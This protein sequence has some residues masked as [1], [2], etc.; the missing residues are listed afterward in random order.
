MW[1]QVPVESSWKVKSSI[2][3]GGR[4]GSGKGKKPKKTFADL[5][6]EKKEEI[7]AKHAEKQAELGRETHGD[8]FFFGELVQRRKSYGWI[9]PNNFGKLPSEV[10]TKVKEMM[11]AKKASV[12][13]HG[14]ENRYSSKTFFSFT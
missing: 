11:K 6:E 1:V 14:S 10:Q 4:K 13:E 9:K 8:T 5:P 7:R 2:Q 12:K 3:K